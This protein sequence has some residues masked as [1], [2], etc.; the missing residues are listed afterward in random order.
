M[1]CAQASSVKELRHVPPEPDSRSPSVHPIRPKVESVKLECYSTS[2][3]LIM[4]RTRV[5]TE[6]GDVE[7]SNPPLPNFLGYSTDKSQY[8]PGCLNSQKKAAT[9]IRSFT[10]MNG[11]QDGPEV[12]SLRRTVSCKDSSTDDP[13]KYSGVLKNYPDC[14]FVKKFGQNK[15]GEVICIRNKFTGDELTIYV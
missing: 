5:P 13:A 4:L 7:L 11:S 14:V 6:A 2:K 12:P 8:P 1:G 9:D 15:L 3:D 10:E